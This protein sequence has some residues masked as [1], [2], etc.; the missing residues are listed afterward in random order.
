MLQGKCSFCAKFIL[1]KW[2]QVSHL[3][4]FPH[5]RRQQLFCDNRPPPSLPNCMTVTCRKVVNKS[6]TKLM[7]FL[8]CDEKWLFKRRKEQEKKCAASSLKIL[9]VSEFLG[10]FFV[11]QALILMTCVI[12]SILFYCD[13][14]SS[15]THKSVCSSIPFYEYVLRIRIVTTNWQAG[16]SKLLEPFQLQNL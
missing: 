15:F 8:R 3:L 1:K 6:S 2:K 7:A 13:K 16:I 10:V 12:F 14:I 5:W 4:I 9:E 11:D